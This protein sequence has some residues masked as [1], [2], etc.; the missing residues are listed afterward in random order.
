MVLPIVLEDQQDI[1]SDDESWTRWNHFRTIADF[2]PRIT[3]VL[4]ISAKIPS[5]AE[6]NR[7]LGEPVVHI[8]IP[9]YLFQGGM[10][11]ALST[12]HQAIVMAFARNKIGC[13]VKSFASD[14][15]LAQ[16]SKYIR[17][18]YSNALAEVPIHRF[19]S[20]ISMLTLYRY[21]LNSIFA[22]VR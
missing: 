21:T 9:C 15:R 4:E 17:Q 1:E 16:F 14:G 12:A 11:P 22:Q 8:I 18:L 6:L 7:W 13:L 20:F 10:H 19:V 5:E 3:V 2:N